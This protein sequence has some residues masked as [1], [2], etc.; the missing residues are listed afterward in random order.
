MLQLNLQWEKARSKT[1]IGDLL[2]DG[3]VWVDSQAAEAEYWS[4]QY[5]Q[6]SG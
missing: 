4:P 5:L 1:V 2:A 6:D 3:L